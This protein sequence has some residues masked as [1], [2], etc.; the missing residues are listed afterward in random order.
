MNI[1]KNWWTVVRDLIKRLN[2]TIL[3]LCSNCPL[4]LKAYEWL[5]GPT[6]FCL[7]PP[8]LW[9]WPQV[10]LL[11]LINLI[12]LYWTLL[13]FR[14][15]SHVPAIRPSLCLDCFP[16]YFLGSFTFFN[17]LHLSFS[18]RP[19]QIILLN[20]NLEPSIPAFPV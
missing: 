20:S 4:S 12:Q 7:S 1:Y 11:P 14:K 6:W 18:R 17:C 19:T 5:Q 15:T 9:F 2:E 13:F 3:L 8:S 16:P 10:L